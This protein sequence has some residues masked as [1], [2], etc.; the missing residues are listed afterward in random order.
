[1]K[2]AKTAAALVCV[3]LIAGRAIAFADETNAPTRLQ[4]EMLKSILAD[5]DEARKS[6][7]PE[8]RNTDLKEFLTKSEQVGDISTL[9]NLW[10]QRA[11]AALELNDD[12]TAWEAGKKLLAF[13]LDNSDD[14]KIQ[15]LMVTLERKDLL[16][17]LSPADKAKTEQE[18]QAKETRQARAAEFV[19]TW[20]LGS[21]P[22]ETSCEHYDKYEGSIV[23]TLD[24]NSDLTASG[25]FSCHHPNQSGIKDSF[26]F[27]G[28]VVDIP[29]QTIEA[30]D[31]PDIVSTSRILSIMMT[32]DFDEKFLPELFGGYKASSHK[33]T[34]AFWIARDNLSEG[35]L[36]VSF[37]QDKV[38]CS[39]FYFDKDQN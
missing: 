25:H 9:T 4:M 34:A 28:K 26:Q 14:P 21:D 7:D 6:A 29:D 22:D 13:H 35:H 11:T 32:G 36:D 23:I 27:T 20:R 17:T 1:M 18:R 37:P 30:G 39:Q 2:L 31:S 38:P 15:Q 24:T 19:G 10:I 8:A 5:A 16:G 3:F 33:T 12:Q